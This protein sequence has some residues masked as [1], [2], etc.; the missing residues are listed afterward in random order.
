MYL[1]EVG[2]ESLEVIEV[3]FRDRIML[4]STSKGNQL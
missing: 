1:E 4:G 2:L 3:S